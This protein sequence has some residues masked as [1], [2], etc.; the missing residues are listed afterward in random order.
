MVASS[1]LM[2]SV[3]VSASAR[4]G[5]ATPAMATD[6]PMMACSGVRDVAVQCVRTG[7]RFTITNNEAESMRLP[8]LSFGALLD[9]GFRPDLLGS[10]PSILT[11]DGDR[12]AVITRGN[13]YFV[14]LRADY[15]ADFHDDDHEPAEMAAAPAAPPVEVA[16]AF[17]GV[18]SHP[19]SLAAEG[20]RI[21]W[22]L[23]CADAKRDILK[24]EF[25]DAKLVRDAH[26]KRAAS[27]TLPFTEDA[28]TMF[29]GGFPCKHV[30]PNGPQQGLQSRHAMYMQYFADRLRTSGA[31]LGYFENVY[32]LLT[33]GVLR[34]LDEQ[35]AASDAPGDP[36]VRILPEGVREV[37]Y[38][39]STYLKSP[40]DRSRIHGVY[41]P[42]RLVDLAPALPAVKDAG[43]YTSPMNIGDYLDEDS[44]EHDFC[45]GDFVRLAKPF[46][47]T[48]RA[49]GALCVANM[50]I[51]PTH[52]VGRASLITVIGQ[53]GN[54]I[55]RTRMRD[56]LEIVRDDRRR[57]TQA[58][59]PMDDVDSHVEHRLPVISP[60]GPM[61]SPRCRG[62]VTANSIVEHP[63]FP[64][65]G[66]F[67]RAREAARA[68]GVPYLDHHTDAEVQVA[69]G[70]AI[71]KATSAAIAR[72]DHAYALALHAAF[73]GSNAVVAPTLS[74]TPLPPPL[75]RPLANDDAP[76]KTMQNLPLDSQTLHETF[77]HMPA[78]HVR[79]TRRAYRLPGRSPVT[80][81]RFC[82]VTNMDVAPTYRT[83]R[84]AMYKIPR[85]CAEAD[86]V[87]FPEVERLGGRYALVV[88]IDT[89]RDDE[90]RDK[91]N[92]VWAKALRHKHDVCGKGPGTP[93]AIDDLQSQLR[94]HG[95]GILSLATDCGGEFVSDHSDAVYRRNQIQH[96]PRAPDQHADKA[97]NA[98]KLLVRAV[99]VM[100]HSANAPTRLWGDALVTYVAARN[101][102]IEP[103]TGISAHEAM[104]G[105]KPD[106]SALAPF[107]SIVGVYD[108]AQKKKL[109][110]RGTPARYAGPAGG[111]VGAITVFVRRN[112]RTVRRA[113]WLARPQ[114]R[115]DE[116][117]LDLADDPPDGS[118]GDG[119]PD[120]SDEGTHA[121]GTP[122]GA[123][124][125]D[126]S[127]DDERD[128]PQP[129]PRRQRT[130]R[131]FYTDTRDVPDGKWTSVA[132]SVVDGAAMTMHDVGGVL[133]EV[134]R[135]TRTGSAFRGASPRPG[136]GFHAIG[137]A[138]RE[139][140]GAWS[141]IGPGPL[142]NTACRDA[143]REQVRR[144]RFDQYRACAA[145]TELA[146]GIPANARPLHAPM[147]PAM[148][149]LEPMSLRKALALPGR[150]K[151]IAAVS[152]EEM[153]EPDNYADRIPAMIRV[154]RGDVAAGADVC[155]S[156]MV[157]CY[158]RP[159]EHGMQKEKARWV[160]DQSRN[161]GYERSP[162][163]SSP[164]CLASTLFLCLAI[165]C[166]YGWEISQFDVTGA[167]LLAAPSHLMYARYPS[168][169]RDF[170]VAKYGTP[171]YEPDDFLLR[172]NRNV[173]GANDA[174]R[175]WFD[176]ISG[177]LME[178]LDFRRC[179]I[180]R[181]CFLKVEG[182]QRV[183]LILYVDDLLVIGTEPLR[184][185]IVSRIRDRFPVTEGGADYLGM[186]ILHDTQHN[187][188]KVTQTQFALAV[189]RKWG[190]HDAKPA[191]TPLPT[192]FV[193]TSTPESLSAAQPIADGAAAGI[194]MKSFAGQ[195]GYLATRTMPHLLYAFCKLAEAAQPSKACPDAPTPFHKSVAART[196]R[197]LR[198]NTHL[199]LR[200]RRVNEFSL[201]GHVDASFGREARPEQG[202]TSG[203]RSGVDI[204]A[205]GAA[206][207]CASAS[208]GAT[209]ISTAQ[210]ELNA[211]VLGMRTLVALR[212]LAEF[213]IGERLPTS[214]LHCDN[215]SVVLMLQ[216]R[217]LKP[218]MRHVAVGLGFIYD[219][220]DSGEVIV[221]HIRTARN[222]AN[223]FTMA[224]S[225]D[226]FAQSVSTLCGQK[227]VWT[228]ASSRGS[229]PQST[230][231]DAR[232][233][234][235]ETGATPPL[236]TPVKAATAGD[237]PSPCSVI[238]TG[239]AS[240][241][242]IT[243]N[244][245]DLVTGKENADPDVPAQ[246]DTA[247]S[248]V[249]SDDRHVAGAVAVARRRCNVGDV[250][251]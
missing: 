175:I 90:G 91:P 106:I 72:R 78:E 41:V 202:F 186:H 42:T 227:H 70:D 60:R 44:E 119:G 84:N 243:P 235:D 24:G 236:A 225:R 166:Q 62:D 127:S 237:G 223:T 76:A 246:R 26:D 192:G 228:P 213:L 184:T 92:Y 203:S 50:L 212:R 191:A 174:G 111:T 162:A 117:T 247:D 31:I 150:A 147:P 171:P 57:P 40:V 88:I 11:P 143:Y 25:P 49:R 167:Y 67:I 35:L 98:V 37:E 28:P 239:P 137:G 163:N 210:A 144:T 103:K 204:I 7:T 53:D 238:A 158:K 207:S 79:A 9:A 244:R 93:C 4:N 8:L 233:D 13:H 129:R 45:P 177:V 3:A 109:D 15:Q 224:E 209:S 99:R 197:W 190:Y 131:D 200:F 138:P 172:V 38:I 102:R 195:I 47:L 153:T 86:V 19:R 230:E 154:P 128:A 214:T 33:M 193:A 249:P 110:K 216:R 64:G 115:F 61:I 159:D 199:G 12:I 218:T 120:L 201:D 58:V 231:T 183:V 74:C 182:E 146:S 107:W 77:A 54:W 105:H 251:I 75:L 52:P 145:T 181:C 173:Y 116:S 85:K 156:I 125:D 188:L 189:C 89:G 130:P 140:S 1:A 179:Q 151:W 23:E 241:I 178:E 17:A 100:L 134:D 123:D 114:D 21:V 94:L 222:P 133:H 80:P 176:L 10:P 132:G 6:A 234:A 240:H 18:G 27:G 245:G 87:T 126:T 39:D 59:I 219:T 229:E 112:A 215:M 73:V 161:M 20:A 165:A 232:P 194:D 121:D 196:L 69:T 187:V 5:A 155:N 96:R 250:H 149:G 141:W 14:H 221:R 22:L 83:S 29:G 211:L 135:N 81:C 30:A 68:M 142:S 63:K 164:T 104:F 43:T 136:V 16:E 160:L 34:D 248:P 101:A 220:I 152:K 242:A 148:H 185:Q 170:L 206:V 124:D 168:G 82:T 36:Y 139:E 71:E 198:H 226:R 157:C 180:D 48:G 208:Q 32:A 46:R 2:I 65:R 55:V 66:R 97:E 118:V 56:T 169:W 113:C 205:C 108:N 95:E 51:R 217:D 122:E